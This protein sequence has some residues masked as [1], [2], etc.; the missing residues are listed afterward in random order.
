VPDIENASA[1]GAGHR[2]TNSAPQASSGHRVKRLDQAAIVDFARRRQRAPDPARAPRR[3][4]FQRL[5]LPNEIPTQAREEKSCHSRQAKIG[6]TIA[7]S[8]M[9]YAVF[10]AGTICIGHILFATLP[11]I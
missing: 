9:D 11:R 10:S 4:P 8:E 7:S 6:S 1:A 5:D 3:F 2:I